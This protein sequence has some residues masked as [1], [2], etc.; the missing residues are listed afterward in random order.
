MGIMISMVP[1]KMPADA[2]PALARPMIK[3][4]ELGAAPQM[5]EPISKMMTLMMNV[6]T[7]C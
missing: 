1:E 7:Q 5:A 4:V 3:I 6:L 2:M